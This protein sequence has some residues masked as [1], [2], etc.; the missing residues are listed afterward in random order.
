MFLFCTAIPLHTTAPIEIIDVT[1]HIK[2]IFHQN[3]VQNGQITIYSAHST[4]FVAINECESMLQQDMVTFLTQLV[5]QHQDFKHNRQPIDGRLNAHSHLL[6]LF[7]N[8]SETIPIADGELLLGRWQSIFF[9]ELDGP[10][11]ERTLRIQIIG[12]R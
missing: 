11:E 5:P 9:I 12:E 2:D 4:A 1:M 7:M 10:R 6:G 3:R 8:A